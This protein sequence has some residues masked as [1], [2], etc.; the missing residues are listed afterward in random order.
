MKVVS[1][2][3][4]LQQ[5]L[6]EQAWQ[7]RRILEKANHPFLVKL[8]AAF[9]SESSLFYVMEYC[10]GGELYYY[11]RRLGRFKELTAQFYAANILL[12]LEHLQGTMGV[13]YRDLKPENVLIGVDGY[14]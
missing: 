13:V 7:E 10:P 6:T 4:V 8:N 1:K 11:L 12:A 14:I 9:Q 2:S 5:R 3:A